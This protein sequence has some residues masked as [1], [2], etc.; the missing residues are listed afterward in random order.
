MPPPASIK[1]VIRKDPRIVAFF[2]ETDS[3]FTAE[4]KADVSCHSYACLLY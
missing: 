4:T 3:V 2:P 1:L